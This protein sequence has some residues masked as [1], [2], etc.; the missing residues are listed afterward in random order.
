MDPE[1]S[2]TLLSQLDD[3]D[4]PRI[5]QVTLTCCPNF[6]RIWHLHQEQE[7]QIYSSFFV[8]SQLKL[9]K[10][11]A[12]F[13]ISKSTDIQTLQDLG[14]SVTLLPAKQLSLLSRSDLKKVLKNLG[15]N[16]QWTRG[17]LRTLLKKQLGD[18]KVS[19]Q[20]QQLV[21]QMIFLFLGTYLIFLL[22]SVKRCQLRSW[23]SFSQLQKVCHGACWSRWNPRQS[24]MIERLW[25]TSPGRWGRGSWRPCCRG[26]VRL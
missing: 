16:V 17:Q 18:E 7:F 10:R 3:C 2:K 6:S 25:G 24:W 15:P 5:R 11:L 8:L 13:M 4:N 23:R 20:G 9:K 14:S 21:S 22:F 26:W 12:K 1:H 19:W